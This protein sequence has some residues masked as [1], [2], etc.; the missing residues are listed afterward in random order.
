MTS[1]TD[2][3]CC[4]DPGDLNRP[5]RRSC[6]RVGWCETSARLFSRPPVTWKCYRSNSR[7]AA[8]SDYSLSVTISSRMHLCFFKSFRISLNAASLF[9]L[10]W[11]RTLIT[12]TSSSTARHRYIRL[13]PIRTN[14]SSRC[15]VPN[16]WV[17]RDHALAAI[18]A[19]N[20]KTHHQIVS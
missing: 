7:N 4:I 13:P 5:I 3:N 18:I 10:G 15:Q 1:W 20:F 14:T 8:A 2:R 6:W 12:S 16:G 9:W 17:G 19:P 11:A